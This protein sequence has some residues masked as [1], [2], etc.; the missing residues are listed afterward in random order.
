MGVLPL[1]LPRYEHLGRP[2]VSMP[3]LLPVVAEEP[4]AVHVGPIA[5]CRYRALPPILVDCV[6]TPKFG[7]LGHEGLFNVA[8]TLTSLI[9]GYSNMEG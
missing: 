9:L 1:A 7:F 5:A 3:L 6:V 4:R 2:S 8:C